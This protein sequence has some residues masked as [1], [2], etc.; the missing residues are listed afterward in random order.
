MSSSSESS[1]LESTSVRLSIGSSTGS[2]FGGIERANVDILEV[3]QVWG[4]VQ[5]G[6]A[7]PGFGELWEGYNSEEFVRDEMDHMRFAINLERENKMDQNKLDRIVVE[8]SIPSSVGLRM[9]L[10]GEMAS[11]HEGAFAAFHPAFLEIGVRLPLH[12]YIWR[13]LR[14]IGVAPA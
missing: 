9:P 8:Y 10:P 1:S 11:N 2:A 6:A 3:E 5:G 4:D 12:P 14:E 13:V 7:E